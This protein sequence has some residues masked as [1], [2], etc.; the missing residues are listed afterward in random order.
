MGQTGPNNRLNKFDL[1]YFYIS[2]NLSELAL[3]MSLD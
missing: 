1:F 3:L 2:F